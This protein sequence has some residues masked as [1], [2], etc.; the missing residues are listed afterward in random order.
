MKLAAFQICRLKVLVEI[1]QQTCLTKYV[2]SAG[3]GRSLARNLQTR[4][5]LV[6]RERATETG[7]SSGEPTTISSRTAASPSRLFC[8]LRTLSATAIRQLTSN[9]VRFSRLFAI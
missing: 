6:L 7:L 8:F 1:W 5:T 9:Q 3:V 4:G 2:G